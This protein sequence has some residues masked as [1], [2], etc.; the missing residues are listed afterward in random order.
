L[1]RIESLK[2]KY[3]NFQTVENVKNKNFN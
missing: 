2:E 3:D 1:H